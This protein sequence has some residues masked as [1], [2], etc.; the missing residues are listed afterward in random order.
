M[1]GPPYGVMDGYAAAGRDLS[2]ELVGLHT[3]HSP[4]AAAPLAF[5]CPHPPPHAY[6]RAAHPAQL[7]GLGGYGMYYQVSGRDRV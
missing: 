7:A 3:L 1:D 2:P 6:L 5:G 4:T